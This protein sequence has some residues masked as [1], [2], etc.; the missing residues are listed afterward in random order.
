MINTFEMNND[1]F[2]NYL[3]DNF[4]I[5]FHTFE[6][7]KEKKNEIDDQNRIKEIEMK[8]ILSKENNA[9]N[10]ASLFQETKKFLF[11]SINYGVTEQDSKIFL[12]KKRSRGKAKEENNDNFLD[13]KNFYEKEIINIKKS[14][15]RG[16]RKK[17]IEYDNEPK[18]DKFAEDNII[19]KIKTAVFDYILEHLNKSL[20][21]EIYKF[22]PLSN[23]LSIN[24]KKDFNEKLLNRTI[25]DIYMNSDLNKNYKNVPD[26]NRTLIKKIYEEK[27][28]IDTINFLGNKFKDILDHIRE[29]DLDNFLNE[30]RKKRIKKDD[31][32]I[33]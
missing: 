23:E 29:K 30:F 6:L 7:F 3:D 9:S 26:S 27:I 19:L 13:K 8:D 11:D 18:H 22:Y 16:R 21:N 32:F 25:Y 33:S 1:G 14:S 4:N 24:I 17:N 28:E 12:N 20:K 2:N 15:N 10:T 31:K 5:N